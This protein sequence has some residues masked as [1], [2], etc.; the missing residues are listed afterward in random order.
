MTVH[1]LSHEP[2][3]ASV[4]TVWLKTIVLMISGRILCLYRNMNNTCTNMFWL[5]HRHYKTI[6]QVSDQGSTSNV[7]QLLAMADLKEYSKHCC[8]SLEGIKRR[9][10]DKD[11]GG[12]P[13]AVEAAK[14][15]LSIGKKMMIR[16]QTLRKNPRRGSNGFET[17][18]VVMLFQKSHS[19]FSS[20]C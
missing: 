6:F 9:F 12:T 3:T 15:T 4:F 18:L 11:Y 14:E 19:T 5:P 7:F 13:Q 1:Q 2:M 8:A 10:E 20:R 17:L 16:F